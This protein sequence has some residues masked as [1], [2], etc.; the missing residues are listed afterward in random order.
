MPSKILG[1]L[2]LLSD[3]FNIIVAIVAFFACTFLSAWHAASSVSCFLPA[4]IFFPLVSRRN[5]RR[6]LDK[7]AGS[8]VKRQELCQWAHAATRLPP[9]STPLLFSRCC[10]SAHTF[11]SSSHSPL[12]LLQPPPHTLHHN[13]LPPPAPSQPQSRVNSATM[14]DIEWWSLA[15]CRRPRARRSAQ[16]CHRATPYVSAGRQRLFLFA[17]WRRSRSDLHQSLTPMPR[18]PRVGTR[19]HAAEGCQELAAPVC[20]SA[21]VCGSICPSS[22][23]LSRTGAVAR[24]A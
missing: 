12:H 24:Y 2:P 18:L 20:R 19:G 13:K 4:R 1:L 17:K 5:H 14:L 22:T 9:A 16:D 3:P 11:R 7:L 23:L 15:T 10:H 21:V 8:A 6:L